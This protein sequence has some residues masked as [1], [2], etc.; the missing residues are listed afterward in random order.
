MPLATAGGDYVTVGYL[1]D[2][3]GATKLALV[4]YDSAGNLD[5]SFG[6]PNNLSSLSTDFAPSA[7]T[8]DSNG[9]IL[10]L[11]NLI[12]QSVDEF[13]VA[14]FTPGGALDTTFGLGGLA[15]TV[16][17]GD[18]SESANDIAVDAA[19]GI[20]VGGMADHRFALTRFASNGLIDPSFGTGGA[21]TTSFGSG[22]S[23]IRRTLID[24]SGRIV[25]VGEADGKFAAARYLPNGQIDSSFGA[26]GETVLS[27]PNLTFVAS[28]ALDAQG[29]I[30]AVGF[31]STAT[32]PLNG[33]VV[34][35][36]FN[37]DGSVDSSFGS[38]GTAVAHFAN[39]GIAALS[40]VIDHAG[41]I[42]IGGTAVVHFSDHDEDRFAAVRFASSGSR[43][44]PRSAAA[45]R[46]SRRSRPTRPP[47]RSANTGT[48]S[49]SIRTT[50]S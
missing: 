14:R 2:S 47:T 41:R 46:R 30:V 7:L 16:I 12:V 23:D 32:Q 8:F 20:L 38:A 43:S 3:N 22:D 25:A 34:V 50:M 19:G 17:D 37:V 13:A 5:S 45:E 36:R 1:P 29:K 35:A 44:M 4:R 49:S 33:D 18:A 28:G 10:V 40:M 27:F 21:V 39:R 26:G 9:N 42:V 11:G 24:A 15:T 31:A 48:P 6:G